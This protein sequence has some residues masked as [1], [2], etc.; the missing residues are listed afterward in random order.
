MACRRSSPLPADFLGALIAVIFAGHINHQRDVCRKPEDSAQSQEHPGRAA[1]ATEKNELRGHGT[2]GNTRFAFIFA[3]PGGS[4]A[5]TP[6]TISNWMPGLPQA[7]RHLLARKAVQKSTRRQP[8]RRATMRPARAWRL[9][10]SS[11]CNS[12]WAI[13]FGAPPLRSAFNA[14]H[15]RSRRLD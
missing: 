10:I 11:V 4:A 6:G 3:T 7:C 8:C 5:V 13:D 9:R 15:C 12:S 1:V 2:I 14:I